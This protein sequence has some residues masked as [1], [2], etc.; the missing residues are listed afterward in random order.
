MNVKRFK[1]WLEFNGKP[2]NTIQNRI[3]NCR[4]VESNEGDLDQH[5]ANDYGLSILDKLSYSVEDERTNLVPKHNIIINGNIRTGS[6]TLKQAVTLYMNFKKDN[7]ID[8]EEYCKNS[9]DE[10]QFVHEEDLESIEYIN[11]FSYENDLKN[12]M[13]YQISEFFPGYKIFGNNEGVEYQIE[14]RRIDILL[15]KNDGSLLV[16]E[17]KAG[18]ANY[19]VIGQILMYIGLLTE[20]FPEREIQGCIIAGEIDKTLRNA[21]KTVEN[22]SLKS[23]KMKLELKNE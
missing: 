18:I 15:E 6:S 16:V 9:L 22:V 12:A 2:R 13:I 19:K 10:N 4:N 5:Y 23:Y 11:N 17:L 8:F 14:G 20:K 7:S 1:L 21:S 3:S